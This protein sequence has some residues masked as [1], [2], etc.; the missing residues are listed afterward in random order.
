MGVSG[1][2]MGVGVGVH[3]KRCGC[4]CGCQ[5][6]CWYGRR[7]VHRNIGGER[8]GVGMA[9]GREGADGP[10]GCRFRRR[11][12]SRGAISEGGVL[13]GVILEEEAP[14]GVPSVGGMTPEVLF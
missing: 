4:L 2:R 8:R 6:R 1:G 11:G 12:V 9:F 14:G 10:W 7:G 3:V 5:W 13:G